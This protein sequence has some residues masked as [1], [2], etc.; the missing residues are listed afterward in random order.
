MIS[1]AGF[2]VTWWQLARTQTA[3]AAVTTAM[4]R[5]KQDFASFEL[6]SEIRTARAS[7]ESASGHVAG[8]RWPEALQSYNSMR[9]SLSRMVAAR[10]GLDERQLELA[11]DYLASALDA[12][13]SIERLHGSNPAELSKDVMNGKLRDF[14]TFLISLEVNLKES[15]RAG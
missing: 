5:L 4:T 15:I 12:C 8:D 9:S 10:D 11:Q 1:V 14:D 6:I 2:A 13:T 3:A 7:A